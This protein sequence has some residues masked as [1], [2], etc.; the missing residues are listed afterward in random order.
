M[1][2]K[3]IVYSTPFCSPC[4]RLKKYLN[5]KGVPFVSVDLM[6]DEEAAD[7]LEERGIRASPVLEV[8]GKCYF[9]NELNPDN[10]AK[11]LEQA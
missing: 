4:E 9:G 1:S 10:L 7:R 3:V 5:E 6:M 8:E 2:G 11:L